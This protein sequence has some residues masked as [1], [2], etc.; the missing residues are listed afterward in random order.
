MKKIFNEILRLLIAL[1]ETKVDA[2]RLRLLEFISALLATTLTIVIAFFVISIGVIFCSVGLSLY[3]NILLKSEYLGFLSVGGVYVL[4]GLI[5]TLLARNGRKPL[6]M[7]Y[8]IK[9]L[10]GLIYE[11]KDKE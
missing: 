8:I 4:V 1:V 7:N 6:F 3:L 10:S 2:M 5:L 9:N 11:H